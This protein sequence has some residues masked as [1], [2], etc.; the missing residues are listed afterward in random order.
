L[1]LQVQLVDRPEPAPDES[2]ECQRPSGLVRTV[3]LVYGANPGVDTNTDTTLPNFY[4]PLGRR[5]FVGLNAK[6]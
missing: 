3:G 2:V 5:F 6:F 1:L 4:D